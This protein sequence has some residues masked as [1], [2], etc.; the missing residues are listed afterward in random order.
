MWRSTTDDLADALA[1]RRLGH[2]RGARMTFERDE[3]ELL[4][5]VRHGR[6]QGG[7][8]A[9]RIGNTEWPKWEQVMSADPVPAETLGGPGPQRPADPA[10]TRPRRPGRHAEV[11]V[12]RRPPGARAGERPR[13][14]CP[15][16][17]RRRRPGVPRPGRRGPAGLPRR[18]HRRRRGSRRRLARAG[19]RRAAGR[20]PGPLPRPRGER[21]DGGRDRRRP[22]GR[23]HPRRRRRGARVRTAAGAGQPRPLGPAAGLPAGG[24]ADGHPGHQGRGGGRRLRQRVASRLGRRTTRSSGAPTA[25]CAGAPRGPAASRVA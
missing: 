3:V 23:R 17:P 6:T 9:V 1:R 19:R 14:R 2:G 18:R 12:R 20:R 22:E 4:G 21:R 15:G 11:R 25:G 13:D 10:A 8:V 5:G 16:R 24:C 7:P